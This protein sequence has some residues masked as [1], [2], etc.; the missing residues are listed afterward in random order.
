MRY[1]SSLFLGLALGAVYTVVLDGCAP[2]CA[3]ISDDEDVVT[4]TSRPGLLYVTCEESYEFNDGAHY[5]SPGLALD[6]CYCGEGRVAC[7]DGRSASLCNLGPLGEPS[8]LVYDDDGSSV[9]LAQGVA[10]CLGYSGCTLVTDSCSYGGWYLR[11]GGSFVTSAGEIKTS[12]GDAILAC[13]PSRDDGE[14]LSG[15]CNDAIEMCAELTNCAASPACIDDFDG[16]CRTYP[17]CSDHDDL[18]ACA[19]DPACDWKVI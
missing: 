19:A 15:Y 18:V 13:N 3:L 2:K 8:T 17:Y 4:C 9:D 11:C 12:V 14:P 5:T 10:A 1:L 6:H 16:S 7:T